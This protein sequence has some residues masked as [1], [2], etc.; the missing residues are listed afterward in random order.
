MSADRY[1]T[2]IKRAHDVAQ[3]LVGAAWDTLELAEGQGVEGQALLES[4]RGRA[5]ADQRTADLIEALSQTRRDVTALV[6]R[7]QSSPV[8]VSPVP[9]GPKP[10]PPGQS[11]GDV[12]LD[13][14]TSDPRL[15]ENK[16]GGQG[17]GTG[18]GGSRRFG[19]KRTTAAKAV[20]DLQTE[21]AD[22]VARE[23]NVTIEITWQIADR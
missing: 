9:V 15:P 8:P 6:K 5:H 7:N 14:P 12:D 13:T 1:G 18:S 19:R 23:P 20:A 21:L 3:A 4:L 22:L 10:A 16:Q 11:A 17:A 2:S